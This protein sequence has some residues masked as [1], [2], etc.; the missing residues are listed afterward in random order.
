MKQTMNTFQAKNNVKE[1]TNL[2]RKM[3]QCLNDA[4]F[5][6]EDLKESALFVDVKLC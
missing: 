6:T 2:L 5:W 3:H 1:R 4:K